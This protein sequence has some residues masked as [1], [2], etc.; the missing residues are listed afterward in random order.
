M[1]GFYFTGIGAAANMLLILVGSALGLVLGKRFPK[2]LH[3]ILMQSSGLVVLFIGVSGMLSAVYQVNGTALTT[4]FSLMV[5][6]SLILGAVVG[7]LLNIEKRMDK[8]GAWLEKKV[9]S[10][11]GRQTKLAESFCF[12]SIFFSTGSMSIVGALNDGLLADPAMLFSKAVIDCSISIVFAAAMGPGVLFSAFSVALY[13]GAIT[14]LAVAAA[15]LLT[16]T[17]IA[18]MSAVGSLVIV[19]VSLKMLVLKKLRIG[20]LIPGIFVPLVWYAVC[21]IFYRIT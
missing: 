3:E 20:N 18:Q 13:E 14:V 2:R 9:V 12:A 6:I 11:S 15:P 21:L 1:N 19:A 5:I 4:R 17:V 10:A 16:D 7:E 8:L